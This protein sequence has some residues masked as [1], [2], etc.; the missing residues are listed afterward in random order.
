MGDDVGHLAALQDYFARHQTLPS[1]ARIGELTGLR[2]KASVAA[3][4]A[5][6]KLQ[7]LLEFTPDKRLKPGARFF[8][9]YLA[10]SV[11]AGLPN[12]ASDDPP[13]ALTI[14]SFLIEKP[15]QTVLVRVKGDSM[16]DAGILNGDIAVVHR[17]PS[18]NVGEVVVAVVDNEFTLKYLDRDK[19]G[20]F[21][22][23]AN[24]AY[25]TIRAQGR[26]E[27]FGVMVGLIRKY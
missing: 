19:A 12:P 23:P 14:D 18:A 4:V 17:Q 22:R 24:T 26:L 6:L 11:R 2:S 13:E 20:Y 27:I 5:R 10:E 21:L 16:Q 1:Y 3:L 8:E 7:G 9:R 25:Q 15:S